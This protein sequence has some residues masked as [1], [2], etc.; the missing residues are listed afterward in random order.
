MH[1]FGAADN[2]RKCAA[3]RRRRDASR[4]VHHKIHE[5]S[6]AGI[7]PAPSCCVEPSMR[8]PMLRKIMRAFAR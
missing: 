8:K 5:F 7:D 1:R 6:R 2:E 4:S 3:A